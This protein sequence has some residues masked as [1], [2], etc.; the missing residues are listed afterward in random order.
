MEKKIRKKTEAPEPRNL[1]DHGGSW[2]QI[3]SGARNFF[4]VSN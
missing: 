4:Q 1:C 3:P 2:V